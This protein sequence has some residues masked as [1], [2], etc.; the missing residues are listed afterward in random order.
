M[1]VA[2]GGESGTSGILPHVISRRTALIVLGVVSLGLLI[3]LAAIDPV[4][5]ED[6]NP[7]IIDLEFA[8]SEEKVAEYSAE[9]GEE[10]D[11]RAR[12]S[13]WV[14]FIYLLAY[15]AFLTLAAA[16]T[17][18]RAAAR[19]GR[20][21]AALGV[22]A[23]PAGAIA[24]A[25]DAIEDVFLLVALEGEGGDLAPAFATICA[26]IK[27]ALAAVA[28]GYLLAGLVSRFG[29]RTAPQA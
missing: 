21:L 29:Q 27:F 13:I 23:V 20:R 6:G 5:L 18:D 24:A 15:G 14:D 1:P 28:I 3:F 8:G 7:N 4:N 2:G 9:W 22:F 25:F 12:L 10:G 26:S 17:R 16:A 11:D 19:G